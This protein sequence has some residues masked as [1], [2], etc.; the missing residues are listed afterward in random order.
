M[1]YVFECEHVS[2]SMDVSVD[3]TDL[4]YGDTGTFYL[5]LLGCCPEV[6]PPYAISFSVSSLLGI[7][8]ETQGAQ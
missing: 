6:P 2:L 7:S 5:Y 1:V 4:I 8:T 3:M